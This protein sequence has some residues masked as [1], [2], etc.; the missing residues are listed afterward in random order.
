[1]ADG[2]VAPFLVP[3][4]VRAATEAVV[5][6]RQNLEKA[7]VALGEERQKKSA[8][9]IEAFVAAAK[10]AVSPA[11]AL[12]TRSD[13]D[14]QTKTF[15]DQ[16]GALEFWQD[17]LTARLKEL[18]DKAGPE[19]VSVLNSLVAALREQQAKEQVDVD[20]VASRI[21]EYE[22]WIAE[23]ETPGKSGYGKGRGSRGSGSAG[24]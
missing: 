4:G 12:R 22:K 23:I 2:A 19:V 5:A 21:A 14:A 3:G 18:A 10:T 7:T 16:E 8:E 17:K 24:E 13:F 9:K 20:N 11:D 15:D 6:A 1:M